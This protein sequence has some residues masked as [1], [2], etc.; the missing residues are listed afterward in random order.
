M[1][2]GLCV[3]LI[4]ILVCSMLPIGV[5]ATDSVEHR[6]MELPIVVDKDG[7][8]T[9]KLA[10][11]IIKND[12]I[13]I[14]PED[15]PQITRYI[16]SA[17]STRLIF[18][19]G[20]K[21]IVVD[22]QAQTL[23][24]NFTQQAFSGCLK[25]EGVHYLP[26][27]ELLPWMNV[28]C[29]EADGNLH[30]DSDPRS[31]W[32][33]IADFKPADYLFDLAENYGQTTGDIVSLCAIGVFDCILD[34]DNIWKKVVTIEDGNTRLYDYEIYKECFREFALPDIGT[35]KD[36]QKRI[37]ELHKVISNSSQFTNT[38]F[39]VLYSEEMYNTIAEQ[40]G[41]DIAEGFDELPIDA[42]QLKGTLK[43]AKTTLK[44]IKT[45]FI[46]T[47]IAI[48][49]TTDYANA[50]RYIYL[51]EGR[52]VPDGIKLAASEAIFAMESQCGAITD[53]TGTMLA[54]FGISLLSDTVEE[55][56][57]EVI[58]T[59][60]GNTILSSLGIYLD[61]VDS[62]LSLVWPVND[63]FS[64]LAKMTV[65]QSIQYDA[66]NAFYRLSKNNVPMSTLDISNGRIA[67]SIFLK[68]AKK[69]YKA[70]Q[71]A[72][73][74]FGGEGVLEYKINAINSKVLEF[75]LS[76]L[77]EEH[78]A[79]EDKSAETNALK[80][81]WKDGGFIKASL[82]VDTT[83]LV[84]T[85][86]L[87]EGGK[88]DA[89]GNWSDI[90]VYTIK[91]A[92]EGTA[93]II[94]GIVQSEYYAGYTGTWSAVSSGNDKFQVQL[95]VTGGDI[96]LGTDWPQED[97]SVLVEVT[98]TNNILTVK[99]ISGDD[100]YLVYEKEYE[101]D[102][103][104]KIWKERQLH[105]LSSSM[106]DSSY[107]GEWHY[108]YYS[109]SGAWGRTLRINSIEGERI[110]FD[111]SYYRIADFTEQMATINADGTATFTATE[112]EQS[113]SGILAFGDSVTV[114]ITHS[115]HSYID[116]DL[117]KYSRSE[118]KP[119]DITF[120]QKIEKIK[121]VF[122]TTQ[123]ELDRYTQKV[124]G[125]SAT[126]YYKN[127]SLRML[128]EYPEYNPELDGY[129]T[130]EKEKFFYY[131]D[132]KLYFIFLVDANT[133]AEDRLYYYDG[134]L[135]RWIDSNSA[136]HNDAGKLK[137]MDKWYNYAMEQYNHVCEIT[138]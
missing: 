71:D 57:E 78:D 123:A 74:L 72:F 50:L 48:T 62:A 79:I 127:G 39:K 131:E 110:Y 126:G 63:A 86:N 34:L 58:K 64:E 138:N 13:Y 10:T 103:S 47:R 28:Q 95:N 27:S 9:E 115:K 137:E 49:D 129:S 116:A 1:R 76:A 19:L 32:E 7:V 73:N 11:V 117:Q 97:Y 5:F 68:T 41:E 56:A 61:I 15:L 6:K 37:S 122:Y 93:E 69:C 132:G 16:F 12:E 107:L 77:A 112:G 118:E 133:G 31:Y 106:P 75:E 29:Y 134:K 125:T 18:Q 23:Q 54:D 38:W 113:I 92:K 100:I 109:D 90:A 87:Y 111:L 99:K 70:Q 53:A 21:Y 85:W 130:G 84:G 98:I 30:I 135:I 82:A 66:L 25:I 102:L 121:D 91:L 59:V 108:Q 45:G 33:V 60:A 124:F 105:K 119:V 40:F 65:Y 81:L 88:Q 43:L 2:R 14:N 26:M 128:N 4:A 114:Y 96:V 35:E 80:Q 83:D 24:V 3:F 136:I 51:A 89:K 94:A 104:D 67:A 120:D 20:L 44:H 55:T 101:R 52:S 22:T 46:Y 36:L 8:A 42:N 17:D